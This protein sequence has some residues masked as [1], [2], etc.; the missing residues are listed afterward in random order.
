MVFKKVLQ[1]SSEAHTQPGRSCHTP[2]EDNVP[3]NLAVNGARDAVLQLQVHLG[4]GV[5]REDGGIRDVTCKLNVSERDRAKRGSQERRTNS[6]RLNH[7]ADG[8]SLDRL[9][10][11]GASRAVAASDGLDVATALLVSAAT[12]SL[13][14]SCS[15]C[16][17][18]AVQSFVEH[19]RDSRC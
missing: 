11:G 13:L 17:G 1:G 4:H 9:V 7:V 5:L 14:A 19:H 8:E 12:K 18:R 3:D 16:E 15:K 6:S 10:L 2:G